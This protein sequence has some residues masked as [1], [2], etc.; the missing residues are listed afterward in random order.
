M[1]VAGY[2]SHLG[3]SCEPTTLQC[4]ISVGAGFNS[5]TLAATELLLTLTA[6]N[7]HQSSAGSAVLLLQL[8]AKNASLQFSRPYYS[9]QYTIEK[10]ATDLATLALFQDIAVKGFY[11]DD[12]SITS[13]EHKVWMLF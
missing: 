10:S 3:G 4:A 8:P 2:E 11:S 9:A 13:G 6:S 12:I 1:D 7:G 5:S